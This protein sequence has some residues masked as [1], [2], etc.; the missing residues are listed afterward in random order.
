MIE[1]LHQ[2]DDRLIL[3]K[4]ACMEFPEVVGKFLNQHFTEVS[5]GDDDD[6]LLP[7]SRLLSIA[8]LSS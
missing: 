2:F 7:V 3:T 4:A 6:N 8:F 5:S 1:Q